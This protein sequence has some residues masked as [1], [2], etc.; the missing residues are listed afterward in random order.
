MKQPRARSFRGCT[1]LTVAAS[2]ALAVGAQGQTFRGTIVGTVI[3]QSQAPVPGAQVTAKN[4]S[5]G[6]TRSTVTGQAG[7]YTIPELPIGT[8][9]VTVE[10]QGFSTV[11]QADVPVTVAAEQ[12][13]DVTLTPAKVQSTIEVHAEAPLVQSTTNVLG[14]V[15]SAPQIATLPVNGR[16]YTK[17]IFLNPGVTGSPDQITDSP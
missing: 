12:R 13:V 5:T 14:G 11:T 15:L 1:L 2:L 9:T 10:L 16:D 6:L 4:Q 17:L 7:D 8:Y 3:D